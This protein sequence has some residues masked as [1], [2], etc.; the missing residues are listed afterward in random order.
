MVKYP[1]ISAEILY[2]LIEKIDNLIQEHNQVDPEAHMPKVVAE[3]YY[4][5][6]PDWSLALE[7][8]TRQGVA[9]FNLHAN[10]QRVCMTFI[11]LREPMTPKAWAET[12]H[13][14][15]GPQ[16]NAVIDY[17][18]NLGDFA[19]WNHEVQRLKKELASRKGG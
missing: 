13:H 5:G 10:S 17:I 12:L 19:V 6:T 7:W 18:A 1:P 9:S 15:D 2:L 14:K 3:E 11:F 8:R 16:W 4:R